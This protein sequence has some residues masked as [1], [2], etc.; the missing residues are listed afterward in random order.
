MSQEDP[1]A[2]VVPSLFE[3]ARLGPLTLRNR[4]IKAATFEG[5]MPRG[6][7]TDELIDFHRRV[8]RGGAAMTT[9]AYCAISPGGTSASQHPGHGRR[10]RRRPPPPHRCGPRRRGGGRRPARPRRTGGQRPIEPP[11]HAGTVDPVQ[12]AGHGAGPGRQHWPA[13]RGGRP[14]RSRCRGGGG[15]RL[16]RRRA[17]PRAQLPAELVHEP[18]PQPPPRRLR[19]QHREPRSACPGGSSTPSVRRS[20]RRWR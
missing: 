10:H 13:R 12:R 1:Q 19:G 8:A 15:R 17:A 5:V 20:D 16:R 11:P 7:V 3:P 6:A 9:V 14:V 18:E 4:I 2:R